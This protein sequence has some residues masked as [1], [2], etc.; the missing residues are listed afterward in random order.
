M[1][2]DLSIKVGGEAG[3]GLQ[4]IG[5]VLSKAFLKDGLYVFAN[6]FYLS[7]VRGGHNYY[8]IRISDSPI[9][10]VRES[11]NI[12]IALDK[13]SIEEHLSE[14][15]DG[16]V[17]IDRDVVDIEEENEAIF[18]IPFLKMAKETSGSRLYANTVAIGAVLGILCCDFQ[19]LVDVLTTIFKKKGDEIVENNIKAAREGYDYARRNYPKGCQYGLEGVEGV[20][21]NMLISGNEAVGL[22][23]LA[24]G[25]KFVASY[26]MSPSTGVMTYVAANCDKFN[27][28]V[29][30]A[31]DEISALNMVIGASYTGAR[32]MTTTSGGGFALMV[33]ALGLAGITETPA[34]IFLAQRPGPA[35]GLPTMTEQGD[36]EFVLH[37]AQ[38]EFPRCVLA[39]KT[40][41]DA[42][43]LTPK[44]FDLADKYQIPVFIL[45]DQYL[46]D[47][48]FTCEK[49]DTSRIKIDRHLLSDAELEQIEDYKRY[50]ITESGISPRA[51]PG[52]SK[53]LVVADSDEHNEEGHIDQTIDNRILMNE[54]RLRKF[55]GL[56]KEIAA[57]EVYGPEKADITL[58]GWGSTYGAL[59][60]SIDMLREDGINA[61][62]VQYSEIYPFAKDATMDILSDAKKNICIE[63]NATGQFARVLKVE[64]GIQVSDHILKY[65]GKPFTPE[66][67]IRS[68]RAM[69]VI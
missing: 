44:A 38:G 1:S 48:M 24:S 8:Q 25:I 32:A 69:E 51:L 28:V 6:Q 47:S 36:L 31:E 57:P 7:R 20:E 14:L 11:I 67:I 65:D 21:G 2:V 23:A 46:A 42:F 61:N 19:P 29:E 4:T 15:S 3:Q 9:T 66:H 37:A 64:T 54:K 45:S 10:A 22:G 59:K 34:V 40:A 49:F 5:Q 12:L 56:E 30:Q 43:Y 68:L 62:L 27:V 39:P 63:N 33:E 50:K 41:E 16:V 55:E 60:E 17:L 58:I 53:S 52:Q 13:A 26:P 35:T 18:H